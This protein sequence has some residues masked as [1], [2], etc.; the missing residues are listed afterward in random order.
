MAKHLVTG[1][2]RFLGFHIDELLN[3]ITQDEV[4]MK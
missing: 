4:K 2:A 1:G 3:F